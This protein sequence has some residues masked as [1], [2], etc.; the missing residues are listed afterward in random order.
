MNVPGNTDDHKAASGGCPRE[1]QGPED[2]PSRRRFIQ[3]LLGGGILGSIASFLYP[4]AK[5]L[6]PPATTDLGSDSV[7][8]A[9]AGD[10]A[11]NTAKIFKFGSRP[12]LL[13]RTKDNQYKAMS[14]SCTHLGCTVQ[15]KSNE[16]LIWC[17]CHNGKYDLTG[18]NISG[19]P[20]RPL[21]AYDVHQ[22][23]EDLV[24]IRKQTS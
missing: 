16:Q 8:A 20:P 17:A 15:Y 11:L 14:A 12:G 23:G 6:V 2:V 10:L 7:I 3:L 9:K 22:Q 13:I 18:R 21:E 24:V 1:A 5:Y 4:V 19:P